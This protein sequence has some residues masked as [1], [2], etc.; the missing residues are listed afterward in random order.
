MWTRKENFVHLHTVQIA[1]DKKSCVVLSAQ[2]PDVWELLVV[3]ILSPFVNNDIACLKK[4]NK[5]QQ[6]GGDLGKVHLQTTLFRCLQSDIRF[7]DIRISDIYP[8]V[9]VSA[10]YS[11]QNVLWKEMSEYFKF[12]THVADENTVWNT[13][14]Q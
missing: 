3:R 12:A 2:L 7:L 4:T 1:R 5:I 14:L 11:F 10:I 9:Q 13:F 8:T 6:L